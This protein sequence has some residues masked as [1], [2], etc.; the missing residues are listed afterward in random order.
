MLVHFTIPLTPITKKNHQ[1]ILRNAKTGR[2]F[3][4]PSKQYKD[5]EAAAARYVPNIGKKIDCPVNVQTVF[6]MP[7]R[8]KVDKANLE[9]SIHDVLVYAGLL[10]DDN[11]DI[12]AGTD[13]SRVYYDKDNPRTEVTITKMGG[14][15]QWTK[16]SK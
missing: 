10:V 2:P 13:G 6:Y 11:R 12:I 3:I 15:E 1:Q 9:E 7:T 8:R 4:M 14:Y 5:Y 16:K